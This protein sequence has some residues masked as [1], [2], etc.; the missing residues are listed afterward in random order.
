MTDEQYDALL[1]MVRSSEPQ[2]MSATT[3][4]IERLDVAARRNLLGGWALRPTLLFACTTFAQLDMAALRGREPK[5][6]MDLVSTVEGELAHKVMHS[7][8]AGNRMLP[9]SAMTQLVR[10]VIEW[11][12]VDESNSPEAETPALQGG[13]FIRLILSINDEQ[14]E[15]EGF[16]SWPPAVEELIEFNEKLTRDDDLVR[17]EYQKFMLWEIARL[18]AN[19]VVLPETVLADTYDTWFKAWP[20][21]AHHD[22]I[23]ATAIDAFRAATGTSLR[24]FIN[25][26]LRLWEANRNGEVI[27]TETWFSD[28]SVG[29]EAATLMQRSVALPLKNYRK[30]LVREREKG[31]LAH[32]RYTFT[33]H[34]ILQIS[35]SEFIT[36]RLIWSLE[37]F[38]GPQ[39]YW[40]AFFKFGMETDP[41][42]E[43]FSQCMN[44]VFESSVDYLFRRVS[45]RSANSTTLI[46]EPEM[47]TAWT[48]GG[49]TP[50]VC[51]WVLVSG[52]FCLLVDATNRWLDANL[53]QGLAGAEDYRADI[54]EAFVGKKF[55]QLKSTIEL[56]SKNGW[57]GRTFDGNTI[58]MPLVVV[59]NAGIPS[60]SFVDMDI[61]I[62]SHNMFGQLGVCVTS[63]AILP[64]RELQ[65]IE[66]ICERHNPRGFVEL[67]AMWRFYCTKN[68]PIPL[69]FFLDQQ[70]LDRPLAPI[71]RPPIRC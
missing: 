33:Q 22:L 28:Q 20:T 29:R 8:R 69:Q 21:V 54:D 25:L 49:Y 66:G 43:Q 35:G 58:Y 18:Q 67:L 48:S 1:A 13:D 57:A 23:G 17:Q 5:F 55:G 9:P 59:S 53:A 51:D 27:F 46:K 3:L 19:A 52:R 2:L 63:P 37:R 62:H 7:L 14:Q 39:L 56:L 47:Q 6:E 41:R 4:G 68:M 32:R 24:D 61:K 12:L 36:L 10:E 70:G 34:P 15:Q 40:E 31:N 60:T 45:K 71:R 50:S 16:S 44:Y 42:G 11:C 65:L 30:C 38:C 64:W 26:G